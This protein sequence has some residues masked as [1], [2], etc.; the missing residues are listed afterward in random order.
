[1]GHDKVDALVLGRVGRIG[2]IGSAWTC[3]V[4]LRFGRKL[5]RI[6]FIIH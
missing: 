1:L 3:E 5:I 4:A 2:D 6:H